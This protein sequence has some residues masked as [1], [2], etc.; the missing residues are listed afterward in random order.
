MPER[1][2]P[3]RRPAERLQWCILYA[4]VGKWGPLV[5]TL[6]ITL[7]LG[8]LVLPVAEDPSSLLAPFTVAWA[9]AAALIYLIRWRTL[10]SRAELER[11]LRA[12]EFTRPE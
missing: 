12:G 7:V 9:G 2:R 1:E 4:I 5:T 6:L 11:K 10:P 8:L 3:E